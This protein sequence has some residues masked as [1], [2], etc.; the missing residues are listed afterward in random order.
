MYNQNPDQYVLKHIREL[1]ENRNWSIYKLAQESGISYSTLNNLFH[2]GNVPSVT[3]LS[4][5]CNGL[6]ISLSEFFSE[7]EN[8]YQTL[9]TEQQSLLENWNHLS[10]YDKEL[11]KVFIS[12]LLKQTPWVLEVP[13]WFLMFFL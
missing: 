12:G 9:N 8:T 6:G 13:F 11:V 4:K 10:Y 1:C 5:I 7:N 2:R 3:T